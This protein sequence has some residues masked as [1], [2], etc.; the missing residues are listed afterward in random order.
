MN[1]QVTFNIL[2]EFIF[3]TDEIIVYKSRANVH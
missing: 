1:I 2:K 3:A